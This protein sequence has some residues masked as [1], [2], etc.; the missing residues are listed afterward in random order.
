MIDLEANCLYNSGTD[1]GT[2]QQDRRTQQQ[3]AEI[4]STIT[5]LFRTRDDRIS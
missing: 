1:Q 5:P 4:G 3:A 2:Q